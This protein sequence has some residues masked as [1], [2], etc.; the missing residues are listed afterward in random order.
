MKLDLHE[1]APGIFGICSYH[2]INLEIEWIPLDS[3][4]RAD[5]VSSL[6]L[7]IGRLQVKILTIRMISGA[8]LRLI[9]LLNIAPAG[10][11]PRRRD[12]EEAI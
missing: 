7:T 11:S 6:M 9:V 1:L 12:P 2:C 8:P 3:N 4:T 5:F 10:T